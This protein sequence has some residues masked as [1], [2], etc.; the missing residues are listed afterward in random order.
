VRDSGGTLHAYG[1]KE[2]RFDSE[3]P[4]T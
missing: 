4:V 1:A 2:I 3:A